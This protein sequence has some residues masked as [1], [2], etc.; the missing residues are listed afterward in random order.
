MTGGA[1]A[2]STATANGSDAV[3]PAGVPLDEVI[4][5]GA[6]LTEGDRL[7]RYVVI[8]RVGAGSMGVVYSARDPDLDRQVALKV[9]R[10]EL[11]AGAPGR[12]RLLR[13][14]RA[15]AR[16]SHPNVVPIYDVGVVDDRVYLAMELVSGTTLRHGLAGAWR[17]IAD[18]YLQAARGLA[19]AHAAGLVHRDFKPDNVLLGDDGRVRVV[20]FG[21]V[22]VAADAVAPTAHDPGGAALAVLDTATGVAVGTPAYMAPEAQRG[23]PV[24]ARA[25]QFSFCVALFHEL[26]GS[27]PYAGTTPAQ[28]V[29]QIERGALVRPARASRSGIPGRVHRVLARGLRARPEARYTSMPALIA[30]LERALAPR[31]RLHALVI[32][33][34][35]AVMAAVLAAWPQSSG[36]VAAPP[37]ASAG[38]PAAASL[39]EPAGPRSEFFVD[40]RARGPA[41]GDR[42][43]P[44][45]S[46]T[47]AIAAADRSPA[48]SKTIHI[49]AGTY[50]TGRERFP[51]ELRHG[52][53][54]IGEAAL[55]TAIRGVGRIDHAAGGT[56]FGEPIWL[57]L[58]VG[59]PDATQTI[60]GISLD[61]GT[62]EHQSWGIYC[63]QGNAY[64]ASSAG[65]T[66]NLVIDQIAAARFDHSIVIGTSDRPAPSGCNAVVTR[67]RIASKSIGVFIAGAGFGSNAENRVSARIGGDT[68]ADG[69]QLIG[70]RDPE[71]TGSQ[72]RHQATAITVYDSSSPVVIRHN[73]FSDNDVGIALN[74]FQND[75]ESAVDDNTFTGMTAAAVMLQANYHL[76]SLTGNRFTG[77]NAA[78][79]NTQPSCGDRLVLA[80]AICIQGYGTRPPGPQIVRAR[81]NVFAGNDVGV[82]VEGTAFAAPRA[83][84]FGTAADPGRN[85]FECN[86]SERAE[87]GYDVWFNVRGA[88]ATIPFAG[89]AWDHAPPTRGGPGAHDG[90]DA[91]VTPGGPRLDLTG[92]TA[93]S[94]ACLAPHNP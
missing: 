68:A 21:L 77:N 13:E 50:D 12:A 26:Y 81:D 88:A 91:V 80:T 66:P 89:N 32:G 61:P 49:A 19:A 6:P 78:P 62:V 47:A 53:S 22:G 10:P 82:Y 64:P 33:G 1:A 4:G 54:L 23:Q 9:L 45:P 36:P 30:A 18:A 2:G 85:R 83:F 17:D 94:R 15:L 60:R 55:T 67:S 35:V 34:A 7:G 41:T 40:A 52:V 86:S 71:R 76:Q 87:P 24:D 5:S 74:N 31:S 3:A 73:T 28:R 46:I 20:D 65:R 25:D 37:D 57:T 58:L 69:N 29:E 38:T 11:S 93:Y 56:A 70:N 48:A 8:G 72:W 27:F 39:R 43:R 14:A 44:Y 16:L 63:D 75:A 79:G 42:D 51:L 59:D 90:T 84:D 92:A